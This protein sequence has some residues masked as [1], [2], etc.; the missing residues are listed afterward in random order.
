MFVLE[1]G[2]T[3]EAQNMP[4][5]KTPVAISSAYTAAGAFDAESR[6][7]EIASA[8]TV[9]AVN[10]STGLTDYGNGNAISMPFPNPFTDASGTTI[11]LSLPVSQSVTISIFNSVGQLTQQQL[12][13][14]EGLNV[15][16]MPLDGNLPSGMYTVQ[17]QGAQFT[18]QAKV[19]KQ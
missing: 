1:F 18:Y 13:F 3:F 6:F 15:W 10:N 19:I 5:V 17:I 9:I 12:Y 16:E 4:F 14:N 8:P 2:L 7:K 11:L